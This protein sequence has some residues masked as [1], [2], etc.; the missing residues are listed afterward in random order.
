MADEQTG[1]QTY[2]PKTTAENTNEGVKTEE[3]GESGESVLERATRIRDDILNAEKRMNERVKLFESQLAQHVISGR[4]EI[5]PTRSEKE[6]IEAE[7]EKIA[8]NLF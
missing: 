5:V 6:K 3:T 8:N 4:A 1:V 7:A 2:T